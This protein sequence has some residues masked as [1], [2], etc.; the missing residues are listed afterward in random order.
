MITVAKICEADGYE[1]F[2]GDHGRFLYRPK[3]GNGTRP[4]NGKRLMKTDQGPMPELCQESVAKLM[5][6]MYEKIQTRRSA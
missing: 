1:I 3:D 4:I 6:D 5:Q 2:F